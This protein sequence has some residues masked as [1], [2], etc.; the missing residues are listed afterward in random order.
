SGAVIR[1]MLPGAFAVTAVARDQ[2]ELHT[3]LQPLW[4]TGLFVGPS[5]SPGPYLLR[6]DWGGPIQETEDPYCFGPLLGDLDL[7]LLAE[8][9]HRELA[10]CLGAHAMV[11]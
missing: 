9:R 11:V 7:Y 8:G 6:I 10:R 4:Q 2:P 5:P 1:A 3:A